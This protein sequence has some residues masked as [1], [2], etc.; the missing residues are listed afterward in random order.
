MTI[1]SNRRLFFGIRTNILI[2]FF[3]LL[4]FQLTTNSFGIFYF[5]VIFK[6]FFADCY[7]VL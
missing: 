2:L 3:G 6:Y 1:I 4:R 5:D 7:E